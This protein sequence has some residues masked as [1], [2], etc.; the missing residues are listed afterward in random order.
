M[1]CA[2]IDI[3]S[4]KVKG[5]LECT[6]EEAW[7]VTK[8]KRPRCRNITIRPIYGPMQDEC[9]PRIFTEGMTPKR[10]AFLTGAT[11]NELMDDMMQCIIEDEWKYARQSLERIKWR[12]PERYAYAASVYV[13]EA[14][15]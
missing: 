3:Y 5:L 2:M 14:S 8:P 1:L 7:R 4:G 9:L 15:K 10:R 6:E 12:Y 11:A 13:E